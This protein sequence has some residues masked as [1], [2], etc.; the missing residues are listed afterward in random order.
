[1]TGTKIH[2]DESPDLESLLG[3]ACLLNVVHNESN[4]NTY[5]NIQNASPLARGMEAPAIV[6]APRVIDIN[7]IPFEEL[8]ALPE[9]IRNKMKSSE[10]YAT[11]VGESA[12]PGAHT[13]DGEGAATPAASQKLQRPKI[14]GEPASEESQ[15]G[16]IPF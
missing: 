4:G 16:D 12:G 2:D 5:A 7:S 6:N 11:R 13:G 9:F 8:D 15:S 10:E 1:M 3:D 14:F